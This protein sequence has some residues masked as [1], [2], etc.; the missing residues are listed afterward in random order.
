MH[1]SSIKE[2]FQI[3]L[4]IHLTCFFEIMQSSSFSLVLVSRSSTFVHKPKIS[5]A[6][7]FCLG[8]SSHNM[9]CPTQVF[10][11]R[12]KPLHAWKGDWPMQPDFSFLPFIITVTLISI[13]IPCLIDVQLKVILTFKSNLYQSQKFN[14]ASDGSVNCLDRSQWVKRSSKIFI[15]PP[16]AH[17]LKIRGRRRKI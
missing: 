16:F 10:A 14:L 9:F 12:N 3:H 15:A 6:R 5:K 1:I 7:T 13:S 11:Q 2:I 17:Q 4:V 8:G